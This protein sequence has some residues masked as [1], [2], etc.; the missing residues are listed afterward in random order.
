MENLIINR[1]H[2]SYGEEEY[3]FLNSLCDYEVS[4][5]NPF[6]K[7]FNNYEDFAPFVIEKLYMKLHISNDFVNELI[8]KYTNEFFLEHSLVMMFSDE[9]SGANRLSLTNLKV[10]EDKDIIIDITRD[11]GISMDMAYLFMFIEIKK[12]E[13]HKVI[14]TITNS[15]KEASFF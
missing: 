15:N 10:N 2:V 7:V 8:G 6:G 3:N 1:I 4:L 5:T 13:Y 9:R 14:P 12:D 11:R